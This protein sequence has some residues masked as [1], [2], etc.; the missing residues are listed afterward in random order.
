[1]PAD[2]ECK[3]KVGDTK[4]GMPFVRRSSALCWRVWQPVKHVQQMRYLNVAE[5]RI[6]GLAHADGWLHCC[7]GWGVAVAV[8][9]AVVP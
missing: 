9:V 4:C 6:G 3:C 2:C 1:M 7:G 8:A 5:D